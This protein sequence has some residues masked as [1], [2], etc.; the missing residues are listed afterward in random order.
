LSFIVEEQESQ[1][2]LLLGYAFLL[3]A[4]L[5]YEFLIVGFL[6]ESYHN[7]EL[8]NMIAIPEQNRLSQHV[9]GIQG[10]YSEWCC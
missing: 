8:W 4:F 1:A 5:Y 9:Q 3:Q 6:E 2:F 7:Q 10:H